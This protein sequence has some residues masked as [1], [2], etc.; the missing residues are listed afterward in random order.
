MSLISEF[1]KNDNEKIRVEISEFKGRKYLNFR[2][3]FKDE[4]DSWKYTKKGITISVDLVD[5]LKKAV[6]K[7]ASKVF[8]DLP[9][10]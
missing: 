10:V 1:Q 2:I 8:E 3:M 6:D 7:A 9:D 5:D 4:D